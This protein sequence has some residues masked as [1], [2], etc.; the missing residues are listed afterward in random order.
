MGRIL[1]TTAVVVAS[2]VA[3]AGSARAQN[4]GVFVS[5]ELTDGSIE[6]T[7]FAAGL[8][9]ADAICDR[10]GTAAIPGSGPWVAWLSTTSPLI[11][12]RNRVPVPASSGAYV[13]ATD[14]TTKVADNLPDLIDGSLQTPVLLDESGLNVPSTT[15]LT[16]TLADGF[17]FAFQDCDNWTTATSATTIGGDPTSSGNGWTEAFFPQ[18]QVPA[19]LYCFGP[20]A[21]AAPALPL[22]AVLVLGALLVA[23]GAYLYRHRLAAG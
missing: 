8:E 19:P 22:P 17:G 1:K 2:L 6:E 16:G 12:A 13:R 3:L 14:P 4:V 20:L 21:P 7:G 5:S 11:P 18:C 9:S 10:L 23:G 15:I